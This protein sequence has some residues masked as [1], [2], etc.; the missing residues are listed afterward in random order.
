MLL[1]RYPPGED[2]KLLDIGSGESRDA[3]FFAKNGYQVTGFDSSA[4]GVRKSI[5]WS[6][7]EGLSIDIFQADIDRYRI[8]EKYDFIFSSGVLHYISPNLREEI[9]GNYKEFTNRGGVHA[10]LVPVYKPFIDSDPEA[11]ELEQ[12]WRSGEIISYYQDWEIDFF[13]EEVNRDAR[14]GYEFA[15]N[16]LIAKEPSV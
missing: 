14:S 3:I 4:E 6:E 15:V 8:D 9:I 11:D 10:H 7:E 1:E 13:A 12:A 2:H 5:A 16:R